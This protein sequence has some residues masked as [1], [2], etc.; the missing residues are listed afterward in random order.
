MSL[1]KCEWKRASWI[2]FETSWLLLLALAG[3]LACGGLPT[4]AKHVQA[5]SGHVERHHGLWVYRLSELIASD[6]DAE[7]LGGF[8]ARHGISELYLSLS[9]AALE[10]PG[11]P[12]FVAGLAAQELRAEALIGEASWANPDQRDHMIEHINQIIAYNQDRGEGE[13][14]LAIHLDIESWIGT[15]DDLSW[16]PP[17]ID[18]YRA[19]ADAIDGTDLRLAADINGIKVR[20][21]DQAQRQAVLDA[22]GHLMLMLYTSS[23]ESV[24]AWAREFLQDLTPGSSGA[25]IGIRVQDFGCTVDWSLEQLDADFA[26]DAAYLGWA[27]FDYDHYLAMCG[28]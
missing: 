6:P 5:Q 18:T 25:L 7:A 9:Q 11:L 1:S 23:F 13:K 16:L 21:A 2:A 4:A 26:D 22:A 8:A 14:F 24:E 3:P 27:L 10:S 17:L 12:R 19:A 28:F 20:R 15:G